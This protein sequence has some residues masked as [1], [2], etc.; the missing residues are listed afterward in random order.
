M[1]KT[2]FAN[3]EFYHIYNQGVDKRDVFLD[4]KDYIRFLL[5]MNLLNDEK[6]GLMQKYRDM[7]RDPKIQS[8]D[9]RRLDL[10]KHLKSRKK[11]VEIIYYCL[12]SNH[13]H[14]ILKQKA[15][16]GIEK[17][18]QKLGISYT[19][20]FNKKHKRT[21]SLFG[22]KFK[23]IHI[24]SNEYLLYLSA[25]VNYNH[26]I[27][28]FKKDWEFSSFK[29]YIGERNGVL[30]NKKDILGQFKNVK[31]YKEFAESDVM[32]LKEKKELERYVLE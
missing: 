5:S 2:E 29:D 13:Y 12:N 19:M 15:D 30:C 16:K 4:D 31:E 3:N 17:F 18:M 1:R 7:K 20:Y 10:R 21:G 27:H 28:G 23:S 6:N 9:A 25:Y 22:G 26:F 11:L 8:S 24:D 32:Y 14:L